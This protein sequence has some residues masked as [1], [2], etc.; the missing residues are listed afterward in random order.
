MAKAL[1][2]M[3]APAT[4]TDTPISKCRYLFTIFARMS[5][6]PVEALMLNRMVWEMLTMRTK[7][8]RSSSGSPMTEVWPASMSRS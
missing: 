8:I 5:S 1:Q 7:Q 2:Q 6:P 4:V 3:R